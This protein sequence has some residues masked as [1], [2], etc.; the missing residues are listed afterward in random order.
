MA[1]GAGVAHGSEYAAIPSDTSH[2]QIISVSA[3]I[4]LTLALARRPVRA[5]TNAC[6]TNL[7][8]ER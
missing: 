7:D 2:P 3:E 5:D 8:A 1:G 4:W 6:G